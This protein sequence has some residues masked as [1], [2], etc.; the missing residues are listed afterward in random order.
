[1]ADMFLQ[2]RVSQPPASLGFLHPLHPP[3]C[4]CADGVADW[5]T[6]LHRPGPPPALWLSPIDLFQ[7]NLAPSEPEIKER[8]VFGGLWV[9]WKSAHLTGA[10]WAFFFSPRLQSVGT[11]Q[12]WERSRCVEAFCNRFGGNSACRSSWRQACRHASKW[13]EFTFHKLCNHIDSQQLHRCVTADWK[14]LGLRPRVTH[15]NKR[16]SQQWFSGLIGPSGLNLVGINWFLLLTD[17]L[18]WSAH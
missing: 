12:V 1:M 2:G 18:K 3:M 14:V 15:P 4:F 11:W 8:R 7:E 9:E 10:A 6:C 13:T 17:C 5:L 16:E